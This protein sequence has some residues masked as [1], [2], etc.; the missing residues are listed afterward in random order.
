MKIQI[1]Q[2]FEHQLF[3]DLYED[4][5][6]KTQD[7]S[8]SA[9]RLTTET[10]LQAWKTTESYEAQWPTLRYQAVTARISAVLRANP[11]ARATLLKMSGGLLYVRE[12]VKD[13]SKLEY[14]PIW[15]EATHQKGPPK[16]LLSAA[17]KKSLTLSALTGPPFL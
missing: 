3:A 6:L 8:Q 10:G 14:V 7:W 13:H 9:L 12:Q 17:P 2:A 5:V 15:L 16:G 11:I 4:S 1:Q